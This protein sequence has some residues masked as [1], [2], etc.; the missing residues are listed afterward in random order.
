MNLDL[1]ISLVHVLI[2]GPLFIYIGLTKPA[3]MIYYYAL[4]LLAVIIVLAFIYRYLHKGL[5]VHLLL[6]ASLLISIF[7]LKIMHKEVPYYLY[8]FL[9]AIGIAAIGYHLMKI[10]NLPIE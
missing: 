2:T 8:S 4:L 1:I 10:L 5:Y 9:I 6:F 7:Y 3:N